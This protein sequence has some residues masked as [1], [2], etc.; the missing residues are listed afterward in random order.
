M[1]R[2]IEAI[3][4]EQIHAGEVIV[5]AIDGRCASGK[6]TLAKALQTEGLPEEVATEKTFLKKQNVGVIHMDDFFLPRELRTKERLS[7]A[8]GNVDYERFAEEV[9]PHLRNPK[10][11]GYKRFDCSRMELGEVCVVPAGN[12]RIVE[13]AYSC[14]PRFGDYM[15]VRVFCDISSKEQ[16]ERIR[17]R[18]GEKMLERFMNEWIPMEE[19]YLEEYQIRSRAD[20]YIP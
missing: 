3:R 11:F 14:H 19:K 13:G 4:K 17:K 20:I 5:I 7:E 12:I 15:T 8:G 10:G 16:T 18:N 1:K 6:T 2:I 9:L